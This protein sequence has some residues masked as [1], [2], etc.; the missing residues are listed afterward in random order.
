MCSHRRPTAA[1]GQCSRDICGMRSGSFPQVS[2]IAAPRTGQLTFSV[3]NMTA[4]PRRRGRGS[5]FNKTADT[6][7]GTSLGPG[8]SCT[9]KITYTAPATPGQSSGALTAKGVL[10]AVTASVTLTGASGKATPAITTTA[11]PSGPL[12]R[13]FGDQATVTGGDNPTGNVT[14][15]LYLTPNCGTIWFTASRPLSSGVASVDA[16]PASDPGTF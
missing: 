7:T 5:G 4:Y 11:T 6:C 8:K 14:F 10:P 9:V 16:G 2:P 13:P 1:L 12:G 15:T 3:G